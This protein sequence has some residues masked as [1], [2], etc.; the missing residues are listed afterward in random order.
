MISSQLW[1]A[2]QLALKHATLPILVG[3][4]RGEVGFEA[5]YWIPFV[6]RM[7]KRLNINPARLIPVTRGGA[8]ALYGMEPGPDIY[9]LVTPQEVRIENRI[10]QA[11]HQQLKQT[12]WIE[13]DR[14]VIQKAAAA[15][16]LKDYLTLHPGWMFTRLGPYFDSRMGLQ[17]LERDAFFD[18][19]TVPALP[20]GLTL[21]EKFVAV[22]FYLRY[23]FQPH[24]QV[25]AFAQESIRQIANGSPVVLLNNG[26]HVDDHIDVNGKPHPNVL[27][28]SDLTTL[29][30]ENNLAVQSAVIGR[31]LGFV[32]TYGG[33]A[34][35]AL[36]LGKPSVSYYQEWGGT[37]IAHKHLADAI[38]LKNSL[39]CIV[40]KVGE[41]PLLQAVV[42]A[43]TITVPAAAGASS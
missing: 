13:F 28:L 22:R 43:I 10:Q 25:I 23:T 18:T 36:R 1:W 19:L 12:H 26:L 21:P 39:P 40:Q 7:A 29:T 3:P 6:R 15:L 38:A 30:P 27:K 41:I 42:P 2:K 24:S 20:A 33:L 34:Q 31:A 17:Q 14:E 5:L 37:S 32:G 9:S 11:K 35:L 8:A 16:E 4:F